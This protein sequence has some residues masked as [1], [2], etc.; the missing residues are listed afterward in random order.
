[1]ST[2]FL[3][4]YSFLCVCVCVCV[5]FT[6]LG[7]CG[8]VLGFTQDAVCA[9]ADMMRN[10]CEAVRGGSRAQ[11][12]PQTPVM[13]SPICLP[14]LPPASS[15]PGTSVCVD[16]C[17]CVCESLLAVA[18]CHHLSLS[19]PSPPSLYSALI[20]LRYPGSCTHVVLAMCPFNSE[21]SCSSRPTFCQQPSTRHADR[22]VWA[23]FKWCSL[24]KM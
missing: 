8:R 2:P 23:H 6:N 4:C 10:R 16:L 17:I 18:K 12:S 13:S 14:H 5:R 1:M 9:V 3:D 15:N 22:Y 19:P 7:L 24:K 11:L 20:P 21:L